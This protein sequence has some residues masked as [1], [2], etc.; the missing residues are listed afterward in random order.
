M[1]AV[2]ITF[3]NGDIATF[4]VP[5]EP[6]VAASATPNAFAKLVC[7]NTRPASGAPDKSLVSKACDVLG[8]TGKSNVMSNGCDQPDEETYKDDNRITITMF[9]AQ[10]AKGGNPTFVMIEK[11]Q[12]DPTAL[13]NVIVPDEHRDRVILYTYM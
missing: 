5:A 13:L 7:R 8:I 3:G 1:S 6:K 2:T 4:T 10:L 11:A 9:L 12:W